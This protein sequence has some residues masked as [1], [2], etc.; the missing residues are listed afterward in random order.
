MNNKLYDSLINEIS[1]A[2]KKS[3]NEHINYEIPKYFYH[4]TPSC[5]LRSIKKNGLGCKIPK[6]RFWNYEN[7]PYENITQG[8]FLATDE[9]VAESY[10]EGSDQFEEFAE[11]YEDRYE[12]ELEIIIFQIKTSDL[13]LDK[14]SLDSNNIY[15]E[16]DE[17]SEEDI[18]PTYFYD[19]I[20]PYN[21]L[22]I[23]QI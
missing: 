6:K 12:K 4:A 19:G 15:D 3:I 17:N 13:D 21:K 1:Y 22:K 18:D 7:T 23:I 20:I 5:Y 11:E 10:L 9:Y 2:V 8:V 14:L 16:D